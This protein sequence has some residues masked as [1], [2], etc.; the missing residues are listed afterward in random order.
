[1]HKNNEKKVFFKRCGLF[2]F[3]FSLFLINAL[4]VFTK[5]ENPVYFFLS[6]LARVLYKN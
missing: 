5:K 2:Y 4:S 6:I 1:M 3:R